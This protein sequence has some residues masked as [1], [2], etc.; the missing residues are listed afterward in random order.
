VVEHAGVFDAKGACHENGYSRQK[1]IWQDLTPESFVP[2]W[3][4]YLT[5]G[6]GEALDRLFGQGEP[7]PES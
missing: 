7:E 6:D 4:D 3:A 1:L 5:G 2:F